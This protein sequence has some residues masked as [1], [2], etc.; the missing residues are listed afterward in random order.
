MRPKT[1]VFSMEALDRD[2]VCLAQAP[3]AAGNFTINGALAAG[4]VATMDVARHLTAYAAGDNSGR[5]ITFTGT[6]RRGNV[7][8]EE[9]T[10]PNAGTV[11]TTRNFKTCTQVAIDGAS[12]GNV[13]I[14]TG[15]SAETQ[16]VPV[17]YIFR[18]PSC[19]VTLSSGASMT[20]SVKATADN[21]WADGF[22]EATAATTSIGETPDIIDTGFVRA[23]RLE[24]TDFVSGTATMTV[25]QGRV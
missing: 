7:I 2:G 3:A 15:D 5:V 4:G 1:I 11:S 19:T 9:V 10:G 14:G 25:L 24:V 18:T 13:E 12:V 16:W 6:D 22:D 20:T 23:V 8:T 17:D 21:P